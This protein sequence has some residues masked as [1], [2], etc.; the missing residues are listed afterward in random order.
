MSYYRGN[1]VVEDTDYC[2]VVVG[3]RDCCPVAVEGKD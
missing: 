3:D 2:L 1:P